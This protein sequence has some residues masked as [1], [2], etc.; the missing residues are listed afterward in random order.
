MK[1]KDTK[2]EEIDFTVK[3]FLVSYRQVLL[4]LSQA[5]Y[6]L[7]QNYSRREEDRLS[8]EE[9]IKRGIKDLKNFSE[10]YSETISSS[11]KLGTII[12]DSSLEV[13]ISA[14]EEFYKSNERSME[15]SMRVRNV[16]T[17]T[18]LGLSQEIS[19]LN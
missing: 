7:S 2:T 12:N 1:I 6:H 4:D 18:I 19:G 17:P 9:R 14:L 16:L 3:D 8:K 11:Q 5:S 13:I 10:K 15:E